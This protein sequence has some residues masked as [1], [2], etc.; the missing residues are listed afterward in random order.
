MNIIRYVQ[1]EKKSKASTSDASAKTRQLKGRNHS[2]SQSTV[3][4]VVRSSGPIRKR[5]SALIV[6]EN[7]KYYLFLSSY[8]I[9]RK[10]NQLLL[11]YGLL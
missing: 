2:W 7:V 6:R 9:F 5:T 11:S 3:E 1:K 8:L 10:I 4:G